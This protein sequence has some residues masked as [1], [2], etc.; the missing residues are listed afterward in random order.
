[1][2]MWRNWQTRTT[3]NRVG[4]AR[5]GSTPTIGIENREKALGS[6]VLT[7]VGTLDLFLPN[8]IRARKIVC[9]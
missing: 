7:I 3:Q 1:M 2:P 4:F 8:T 9:G 6:R 5:V